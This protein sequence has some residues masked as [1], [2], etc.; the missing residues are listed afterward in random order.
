MAIKSSLFLTSTGKILSCGS[1]SYWQ[2]VTGQPNTEPVRSP[3]ETMIKE[4][5]TFCMAGEDT[6]A[7]FIGTNP[8][9]NMP[10]K[11]ITSISTTGSKSPSV[12]EGTELIDEL[13][14]KKFIA[15][16]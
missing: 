9:P 4:G 15:G 2:L 13:L 3:I 6:T 11:T 1:N 7:V 8:P 10:N 14:I 12:E 16:K 5:A